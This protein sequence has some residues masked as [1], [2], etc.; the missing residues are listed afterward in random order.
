MTDPPL[1]LPLQMPYLLNSGLW[2]ESVC[3][4]IYSYCLIAAS[5]AGWSSFKYM[6]YVQVDSLIMWGEQISSF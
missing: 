4:S 5:I 3:Q 2:V 6:V 1:S